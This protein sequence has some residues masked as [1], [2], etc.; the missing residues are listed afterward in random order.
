MRDK[1]RGV[2]DQCP[3]EIAVAVIGGYWKITI[4]K[5]LAEG[6]LRFSE[7][8]RRLPRVTAR[9]LTRQLRELEEDGVVTRTV[10][11]QVP[12]KVEYSLSETGRTLVPLVAALDAWGADYARRQPRAEASSRRAVKA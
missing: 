8:D 11:P 2:L 1:V 9:M 10:Y 4:V 7:L 3:A 6:T 5:Y 12:P